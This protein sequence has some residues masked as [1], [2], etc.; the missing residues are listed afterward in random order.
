MSQRP[1][2]LMLPTLMHLFLVYV[3]LHAMLGT[4]E[5]AQ[6][7]LRPNDH[8]ADEV[9]VRF[10]T[11]IAETARNSARL[12]VAG[13]RRKTFRTLEGLELIK[14]PSNLTARVAIEILQ[15]HPD[16]LYAEPNYILRT[17]NVPNDTRFSEL[18]ALSNFGQAGGTAGADIEAVAA[19]DLSTGTSNT[20]IAVIDSGVDYNHPD[21]SP[22]MFR[23]TADCNS[24][25]IDDDGNGYIDDCY[26]IDT[27]NNDSNPMDDNNHGT[28]VAG[29]IGAVGNNNRG[30]VGINWDVR[31]LACKFVDSSGSGTTGDA[32]DCLEYVK[33]MKDRGYN[34]VATSNSWGGGDYSQAL[35]DAIEAQHQRGILFISA[36]GNGDFFGF[37][38]DND[39]TS[40]YPCD[41]FLPNVI[42]VASTTRTDSRSTFSNYGRRTVHI[43]A[44]GSDILSTIR[45]NSYSTLSGTSMA[46]PHVSGVAALLKAQEPSRD[47]RAIK[48]LILA[49][50]DNIASMEDTVSQKR[51]N[52]RGALSCSTSPL[53]SRLRPINNA[54]D[55]SVGITIN[56]VAL[57]IDCANPAGELN[58]SV[59]PSAKTITLLDNGLGNDQSAGDGIYSGQWIPTS[60][61]VFT[62][63]FSGSDSVTVTVAAPNISVSPSSINF[64]TV[65]LGVQVDKPFIVKNIGGGLLAGEASTIAPFSVVSGGSYE[66]GA[67]QSQSIVVRFAPNALG[68]F[69][70]NV[71]FSG[72]AGDSRTVSGTAV[73]PATL[74]ATPTSIGAGGTITA[75]WSGIA[76]PTTQDWIG[77]YL[78]SAPQ[79][80]STPSLA[81]RYT[82]GAASGNVPLTIPATL[83]PGTYQLRLFANNGY[84][85]L[86]VSN[87]FVVAASQP[88][89]LTAT[90]TSIGA[91]GTITAAWSGIASPT[92]KDWIGLYLSSAPQGSS[93]PSLA[94]RYTT[95]AASGN[96]PLTIPATLA[97]G[98][99]QLRL[100]ANN[101]YT[102]LAVSNSFVVTASQ[103]ATLTA[104]PTSIGAGGTITAAWSGI[105]SPTTKDWIGLYLPSAPQGSSTPSLAWRYT[106][107][108]ASGN[109]PLTIPAT[110]APG[111][112]QLRLFA[113]NGYTRLAVSNSF[114]VT[115]A[116]LAS[117]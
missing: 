101:G 97:P 27:A 55:G 61:G 79:G 38:L 17:T 42:C 20:I 66:L 44:P 37:G 116:V 93:T 78:P 112:Y 47:W 51:L 24:N 63:A 110:L 21:L 84:T 35:F 96:V 54:I 16:I 103:P 31:L 105:A 76:S 100:F 89:T 39:Q 59:S 115:S 41:Y 82:T 111:T 94:W 46:T 26:G 22:N 18:W 102:R 91:G 65:N 109:V 88:A 49:G 69:S 81:W 50:G 19:W 14:L 77:L 75:A 86:A 70:G 4:G 104:T 9:L 117:K 106:T 30:V 114:V 48:N 34:I 90:P 99:Y 60:D 95:G 7:P 15:R 2:T 10:K 62:L 80:S 57:N 28:H 64:G 12:T 92:T 5:T 85:R 56:L 83:A 23:N 52:A 108:A 71:N 43:G 45:N 87:S 98:T 107:G 3:L 36:A 33:I 40:F 6:A 58:V 67:G 25:G 74:T 113:N 11:G 29:T 8:V 68:S 13:T 73:S 32:I 72:A 1:P 53:N